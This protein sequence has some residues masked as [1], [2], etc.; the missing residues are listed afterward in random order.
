[1]T[2]QSDIRTG[3]VIEHG[4]SP[5]EVTD[6]L[7]R[8]ELKKAFVWFGSGLAVAL[9]VLMIQPIMIICA[10]LVLA[11]LFDGGVRLLGRVLPI[12]RGWRLLIVVIGVVLFLAGTSYLL[13]VGVLHQVEQLRDTVQQQSVRVTSYL[14][15]Q[16]LMPGASDMSG[17]ARQAMSSVGRLTSWVG[18]AV[19]VV[20]TGFFMLALGLFFAAEPR[21][22]ER[23]VQ[24]LVPRAAR[25]E[26]ALTTERIAF[27]LRRLFAGK[28]MG[29][30]A[31]GV[32]T[33]IALWLGGVPLALLL[34]IITGVL[35]FI[36]NIGS[37]ISGVLMIAMG[38][39]AGSD[40][41]LW[42][43]GTW[44]FIQA[45][46]GYILNPTVARRTV[47]MPPA[48]TLGA[49]ILASALFGLLGL[50]LADTFVVVAKVALERRAERQEGS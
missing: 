32:L 45:F 8:A 25:P 9:V 24:W 33:F 28:L 46:D 34:G 11:I 19:G 41:G 50:A 31:E 36:P 38:F 40:T 27:T 29:M 22:Y 35:A 42:A 16:G 39:S 47:D 48:L 18:T 17:I 30:A 12:A 23:G 37:F 43:L 5:N 3:D 6:P 7:I 44:L 10:G 2:D 14:T 21:M 49:Q 4:A 15:Q 20:T 13:G 1:M 26:F